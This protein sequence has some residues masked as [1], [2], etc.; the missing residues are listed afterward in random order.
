MFEHRPLQFRITYDFR[1]FVVSER[2][3]AKLTP[4]FDRAIAAA[5]KAVEDAAAARAAQNA[6]TARQGRG[7]GRRNRPQ[8]GGST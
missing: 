8:G 2:G 5:K 3:E 4:A 7:S 1:D 6:A